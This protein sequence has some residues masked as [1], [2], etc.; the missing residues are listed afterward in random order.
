MNYVSILGFGAAWHCGWIEVQDL[1][2]NKKYM[3]PCNRWLSKSDDDKQIVRE[4]T[5]STA[6]DTLKKGDKMCKHINLTPLQ[7]DKFINL[8]EAETHCKKE[9]PLKHVLGYR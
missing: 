7:G 5:C 4:L 3:F 6:P 9:Y 8:L 2:K 1:K